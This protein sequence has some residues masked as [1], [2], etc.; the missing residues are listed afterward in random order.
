MTEHHMLADHPTTEDPIHVYFSAEPIIPAQVYGPAEY[1]YPAEGGEIEIIRVEDDH[2]IEMLLTD[3]ELLKVQA[4]LEGN[5][6]YSELNP[7][8]ERSYYDV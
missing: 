3:A 8:E 2:G 6:D 7:D 5:F 1:C 4:Y